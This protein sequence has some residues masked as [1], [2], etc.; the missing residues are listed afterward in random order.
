MAN[1]KKNKKKTETRKR[2]F[3]IIQIGS[4]K[5]PAS[6][7]FDAALITIVILNILKIGW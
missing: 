1:N 6:A 4:R 3:E 2:I 7:A 5:D